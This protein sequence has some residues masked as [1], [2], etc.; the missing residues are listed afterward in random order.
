[1]LNYVIFTVILTNIILINKNQ[2]FYVIG[3]VYWNCW[4][5]LW[6]YTV[7]KKKHFDIMLKDV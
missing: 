7:L 6:Y 1:M 3:Q 4:I 5:I 2:N